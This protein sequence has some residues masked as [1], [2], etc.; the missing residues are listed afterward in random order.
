MVRKAA[1][2]KDRGNGWEG[3]A[4][5][6]EAVPWRLELFPPDGGPVR[7]WNMG[8]FYID[9]RDFVSLLSVFL[10]AP[11]VSMAVFPHRT[12]QMCHFF[13]ADRV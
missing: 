7:E 5:I 4:T 13:S 6:V 11:M 8:S 1:P 10:A 12:H 2:P 3:V 9:G